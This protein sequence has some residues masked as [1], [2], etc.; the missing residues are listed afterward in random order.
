MDISLT[1]LA[2]PTLEARFC[3]VYWV[4]QAGGNERVTSLIAITPKLESSAYFAPAAHCILSPQKLRAMLGSVRGAS[5]QGILR[6][7]AS[8]M[9]SQ[10][11]AG[12]A[13]EDLSAPFTGF[14]I[15]APRTVRGFSPEQLMTAAVQM[16]STFGS[17]EEFVED[18]T[19]VDAQ[20]STS[21]TREFLKLVKQGFA[22]EISDRK[23]RFHHKHS[24]A[25]APDVT[26]DY[27]Y[28][29]WL[30]QFASLPANNSQAWRM[31]R[32]AENKIFHI[33]T[34]RQTIGSPTKPLL[35]I[36]SQA[37]AMESPNSKLIAKMTL[38]RF[39]LLSSAHH[40]ETYAAT[41]ETAAVR[42]LEK[43]QT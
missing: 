32:E 36:N 24:A 17:A 37:L 26:L 15:G 21:T 43:L 33:I 12:L 35:I 14:S 39:K 10:L 31:E 19:Q 2:G 29:Q 11:E 3:P 30:V 16:V 1:N 27:Q 41:D 23:A 20:V 13:L 25:G 6:E 18:I 9:T 8:F 7:V 40:I 5:A 42:Q 28:N 4:P 22:G 38:D 34:A